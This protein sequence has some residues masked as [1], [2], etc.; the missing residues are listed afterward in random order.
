MSA[1]IQEKRIRKNGPGESASLVWYVWL[2]CSYQGGD[3][4]DDVERWEWGQERPNLQ[5]VLGN[6]CFILIKP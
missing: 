3:G 5:V 6:E 4:W 1:K 2:G